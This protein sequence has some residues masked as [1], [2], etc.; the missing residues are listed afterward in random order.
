MITG[1][2]LW[3]TSLS[4]ESHQLEDIEIIIEI[5]KTEFRYYEWVMVGIA[6]LAI[7]QEG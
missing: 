4:P 6:K 2:A 3:F 7:R 5:F 1:N